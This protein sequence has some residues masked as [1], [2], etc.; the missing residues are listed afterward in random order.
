MTIDLILCGWTI[1]K[2]YFPDRELFDFKDSHIDEMINQ[3]RIPWVKVNI[4][5]LF[6][7]D[8]LNMTNDDRKLLTKTCSECISDKILIMHWT[9]TM[10]ESAS[11]IT[12][13]KKNN[14]KTIVFFWAMLPYEL[15]KSDAMFNLWFALA[16]CQIL[17]NW[18]YVSMNWRIWDYDKVKKDVEKAEFVDR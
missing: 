1:N 4:K 15:A 12:G 18:I 16:S 9:S 11:F 5:T 10:V 3:A 17:S 6:L 7:K 13:N 2:A 8:S 14:S